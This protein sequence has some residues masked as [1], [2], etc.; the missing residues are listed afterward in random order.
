MLRF[1]LLFPGVGPVGLALAAEVGRRSVDC[2]IVETKPGFRDCSL[3]TMVGPGTMDA[4]WTGG[5]V[6]TIQQKSPSKDS[7]HI[8]FTGRFAE[9]EHGRFAR[10]GATVPDAGAIIGQVA[11]RSSAFGAWT[12]ERRNFAA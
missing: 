10:R 1:D 12:A 4:L 11:G 5:F 3:A 8:G 6:D 7:K 9:R 2:L